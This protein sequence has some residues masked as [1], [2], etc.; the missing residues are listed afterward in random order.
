MPA[1]DFR[2]KVEQGVTLVDLPSTECE[3]IRRRDVDAGLARHCDPVPGLLDKLHLALAEEAGRIGERRDTTP[4]ASLEL[5]P[6]LGDLVRRLFVGHCEQVG[7]GDGM[8]LERQRAVTIQSDDL[9]P[10]EQRWLACVPTEAGASVGDAGRD[11]DG[12]PK[13]MPRE[14]RQRVLRHVAAAVVEAQANRAGRKLPLGEERAKFHDVDDSVAFA[15][16]ELHLFAEPPNRHGQHVAVV[17][18]SVVEEHSEPLRRWLTACARQPRHGTR[19]CDVRLDGVR[20]GRNAHAEIPLSEP[21][22]PDLVARMKERLDVAVVGTG[23]YGLSVSAHLRGLLRVRAFGAPMHTW[24]TRMPPDMRLRSDWHETSFSTPGNVATFDRWAADTGEPREEPIPLQK[25]LRYS[26]WFCDRYAGDIDTSDIARVERCNGM[27]RL[28][29]A[30]NDEVDVATLVVAVGAVPFAAAPAP[31]AGDM[32]DDV[33]FATELQDYGAYAS[34]RVVVVGGGQGGL[35]S[36]LLAARA[37]ADVQMVVRS[38]L[39]WFTDREPHTRRSALGQRLYRLA[40]PAV[41]YGPPPLNRLVMRPDLFS[42]LPRPIRRRLT[43]RVLRAGGSPWLRNAIEGAVRIREGAAV[44][45]IDR[46]NGE[47]R[48]R[49]TDG[50]TIAADAVILAAGFRFSLDRLSFLAPEIRAGIAMEEGWPL[51]DGWF[52]STDRRIL[53]V[54]FASEHRFGPIVRFIPGTRFSAP[55]VGELLR[56]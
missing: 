39:R 51:L 45:T 49:L 35:E 54:G 44:E 2:A 55:R 29:S 46:R 20:N 8:R 31:F 3:R 7:M 18:D 23:P 16:Q 30:G 50:A 6:R 41:G 26:E 42:R 33:R 5:D 15:R 4:E 52:R 38:S 56:R 40:Y 11:E 14:H 25:F 34:R 1:R 28:T 17:G 27:F 21:V 48:L 36:A 9:P 53:F 22:I 37:G 24:R 43:H 47:I 10:R 32:D 19:A 13:A 12:R